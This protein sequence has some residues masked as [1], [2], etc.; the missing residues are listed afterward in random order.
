MRFPSPYGEMWLESQV[1]LVKIRITTSSLMGGAGI[2]L[3]LSPRQ[4]GQASYPAY[5]FSQS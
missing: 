2:L 1:L 3:P 5:G 4:T